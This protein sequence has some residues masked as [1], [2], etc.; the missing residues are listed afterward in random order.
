MFLRK[1]ALAF[2]V[3]GAISAVAHG[4]VSLQRKF[5]EGSTRTVDVTTNLDQ[6]LVFGGMNSEVSSETRLVVTS[7]YGTRDSAGQ[8]RIDE[9][10]NSMQVNTKIM[11]SEYAFDSANPDS[12]GSSL[13]EILRPIHKAISGRKTTTV[14]DKNNAIVSID[15]DQS[16]LNNVP[17]GARA[18]VAGQFDPEQM[19]RAA[20]EESQRLPSGPVKKGD[21]W[22]RTSKLNLSAGQIMTS[23][24]NYTYEGEVEKDGK[25]LDKITFKTTAVEFGLENSTLP[26][27]VKSSDLKPVESKG[28]I[29]FDREAGEVLE[30]TAMVRIKGNI[31]FAMNDKEIPAEL[32]L[33]MESSLK[34]KA[35]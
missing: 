21:T 29:W 15:F 30:Q 3:V 6:T 20:S 9:T 32:D 11:G 34:P 16:V 8:L 10:I 24:T 22:E 2:C 31:M 18:L 1:V 17:E 4:Q 14:Y 19:K 33:K 35:Q 26:F 25:K 27:T 7:N 28:E 13:L 23:S 5:K 12:A